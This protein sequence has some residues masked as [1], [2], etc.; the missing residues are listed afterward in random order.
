MA[1]LHGMIIEGEDQL[2]KVAKEA[3][4]TEL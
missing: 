4:E 2:N 1:E 3:V